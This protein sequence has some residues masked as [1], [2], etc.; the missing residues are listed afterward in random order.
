[1]EVPRLSHLRSRECLLLNKDR[2]TKISGINLKYKLM[3]R[4]RLVSESVRGS[5][6]SASVMLPPTSDGEG[7][8]WEEG[9]EV[10]DSGEDED[11]D[12]DETEPVVVAKGKGKGKG[13]GKKKSS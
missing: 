11:E 8:A 5:P 4:A 9:G 6:Y 2:A 13:K 10:G 3:D 1:M 12:E 7:P